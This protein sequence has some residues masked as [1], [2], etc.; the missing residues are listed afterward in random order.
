M[1]CEAGGS[2][3]RAAGSSRVEPGTTP[4]ADLTLHWDTWTD[5]ER[6]CGISRLWGG[7]H[8]RDAIDRA[9]PLGHRIGDTAYRFVRRHIEGTV[10][11]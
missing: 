11:Q 6:E 4:A 5:F 1:G 2:P 10:K 8:F 7:V 9:V 3:A